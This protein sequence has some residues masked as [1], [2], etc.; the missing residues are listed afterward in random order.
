MQKIFRG[1]DIRF[2]SGG[3]GGGGKFYPVFFGVEVVI[4]QAPVVQ[5]LDSVIHRINL[6]LVDNAIG[7][8]NMYP[9]DSDLSGG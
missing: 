4:M 7:L 9:L 2:F 1:C 5:K 8:P 6:Y 3:A